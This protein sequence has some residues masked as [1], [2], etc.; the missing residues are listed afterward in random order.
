[1]KKHIFA[2]V[3]SASVVTLGWG[4]ASLAMKYVDTFIRLMFGAVILGLVFIL[5]CEGLS[6]YK[7]YKEANHGKR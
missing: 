4:L 2:V 1:M 5:Y 3:F 6:I 7:D